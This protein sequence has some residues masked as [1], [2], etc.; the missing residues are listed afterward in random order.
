MPL[1]LTLP[2]IL[3]LTLIL[4]NGPRTIVA[5][6]HADLASLIVLDRRRPF[7]PPGSGRGLLRS[8][9]QLSLSCYPAMRGAADLFHGNHAALCNL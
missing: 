5:R 1:L 2:L 7:Q 3:D 8:R 6:A 9:I 4:A